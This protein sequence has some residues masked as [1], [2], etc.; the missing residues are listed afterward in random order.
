MLNRLFKSLPFQLFFCILAAF[1]FGDYLSVDQVRSL[2]TISCM[3][4]EILMAILPVIIFSYIA[5]AILSLDQ[6]APA[7]I[8]SVVILVII[9]NALAAF[10]SYGV[11]ISILPYITLNEGA[12]LTLNAPEITPYWSLGIPQ[13]F[14][15]D[16][17]MIFGVLF[18][19]FFTFI[20]NP[21]VNRLTDS[22]Q[23][24]VTSFL[25]RAF[26]PLL[27]LYVLGFVIKMQ[28]EGSLQVLLKNYGQ[29]FGLVCVVLF[30]YI[31]FMYLWASRFQKDHFIHAIKQ[32]MPAGLTGFSTISSAVTM[33]VTLAAT[34]KNI[35]NAQFAH[36]AIPATVNIHMIGH[37]LSIPILSLSV[38]MLSGYPLPD[39]A[40]FSVFVVFYCL[41][42]F[43][44]TAIPGGG[45]IVIVPIL[46]NQLGFTPEMASLMIMLD[47]LQDPILTGANVMG[48]GAFAMLCYR[49]CQRLKL[50]ETNRTN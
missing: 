26:V 31:V 18:G 49:V 37:G 35:G 20:R 1:L 48:N 17:A 5:A 24:G 32:M 11:G 9:S 8:L 33:P 34:E 15:P 3:L 21:L 2:L 22:L 19:L 41:A 4:K 43:S 23:Q 27:P 39:L 40:S 29:V 42:K 28:H 38:L 10:V 13:L 50:V 14:S 36:L 6:K 25:E 44:A 30:A 16:R 12:G 45:I 7:L 46:Q 47:V